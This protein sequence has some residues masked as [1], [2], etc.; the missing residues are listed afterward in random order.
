M[1]DFKKDMYA[2]GWKY[3]PYNIKIIHKKS[4]EIRTLTF[5][6]IRKNPHRYQGF[7]FEDR[8]EAISFAKKYKRYI[9]KKYKND[10]EYGKYV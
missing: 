10:Q 8:E 2:V 5:K 7:L 6:A 4:K 9:K 1:I 3:L